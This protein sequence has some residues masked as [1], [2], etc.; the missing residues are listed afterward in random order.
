MRINEHLASK[1]VVVMQAVLSQITIGCEER[2]NRAYGLRRAPP[3]GEKTTLALEDEL[4]FAFVV[5]A[6]RQLRHF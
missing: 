2:F 4:Q 5:A 3:V 1:C 6:Q